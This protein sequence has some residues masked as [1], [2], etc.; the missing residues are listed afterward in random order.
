[1]SNSMGMVYQRPLSS[2]MCAANTAA[3]SVGEL[4]NLG[5]CSHCRWT[6]SER[7]DENVFVTA[8]QQHATLW[9]GR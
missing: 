5:H 3:D 8:K 2:P 1:M 4:E 7:E 6:Y 9:I